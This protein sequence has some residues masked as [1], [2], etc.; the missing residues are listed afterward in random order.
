MTVL[1]IPGPTPKVASVVP[2]PEVVVVVPEAPVRQYGPLLRNTMKKDRAVQM[3]FTH[4]QIFTP[5]LLSDKLKPHVQTA[6]HTKMFDE[7]AWSTG[8]TE[9]SDA[10]FTHS[11]SVV[12]NLDLILK[13]CIWYVLLPFASPLFFGFISISSS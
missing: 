4:D 13:W 12:D 1:E 6:L 5:T 3:I 2:K 11:E 9:L 10:L 8:L 7:K